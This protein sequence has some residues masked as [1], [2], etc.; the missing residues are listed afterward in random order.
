MSLTAPAPPA[1]M[2][3]APPALEGRNLTKYFSVK[4]G[5][6]VF[7]RRARL[8]AVE[9]VSVSLPAGTVTGLVGESGSG[10]TTV[11][12]LL[13][14]II[15]P[16]RGE[17]LIEGEPAPSGRPR[18]YTS[19][20]QMVLQDPF[21]SLNPVYRVRHDLA[22]PLRIHHIVNDVE[23]GMM[24][25]LTRVALDPGRAVHRQVSPRA[26]RRAAPAGGH[27]SGARRPAA[28]AAR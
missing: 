7:S 1:S 13:A 16:D 15:P 6:G 20:V 4:R 8:Y 28:G 18:T 22:R 5:R 17:L 3:A 27:R 11:A 26:V 25:L 14:K 9:D 23:A 21:S 10:K 12:R 2:L 19:R 24:D